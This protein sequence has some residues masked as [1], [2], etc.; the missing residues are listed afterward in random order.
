[1]SEATSDEEA[2]VASALDHPWHLLEDARASRES[3]KK[4]LI[5]LLEQVGVSDRRVREDYEG[6]FAIELLQNAHDACF[7]DDLVGQ[8]WFVLTESA[9]LVGNQG[10][11]FDGDR[12]TALTRLGASTKR[13]DNQRRV[14]GYK[15]IGF[16]SVFSVTN[17]P[18]I[19]SDGIFFGFDRAK[20]DEAILAHLGR[21]AKHLAARCFPFRLTEED[22]ESDVDAVGAL[23]AQGA[24]TVI[25][26]PLDRQS[27]DEVSEVV[28]RSLTAEALLFMPHLDALT[29]EDASG[30]RRWKRTEGKPV[31]PGSLVH[32]DGDDG[33]RR[34]WLTASSTVE[35]PAE[36]RHLEDDIWHTVEWLNASV[37]LPWS[38]NKIDPDRGPQTLHVYFPTDDQV[39]RALLAHG[40]FFLH[41]SRRF[42]QDTGPGG[43]VTEAVGRGVVELAVQLAEAVAGR[44]GE[45]L[46]ALAYTSPP[47]GYGAT[48]S[49]LLDER[50]R[51]AR[52][53]RSHTRNSV[54]RAADLS[55]LETHLVPDE[56]RRLFDA[57][58]DPHTLVAFDDDSGPASALLQTL[59]VDTLSPS[60][61]AE[62][63]SMAKVRGSY[64]DAIRL[65]RDWYESLNANA[66]RTV[67]ASL[68]GNATVRDEAGKWRPASEVRRYERDLPTPPLRLRPARLRVPSGFDLNAFVNTALNVQPLTAATLF[69]DVLTGVADAGSVTATETRKT[70]R[71]LLEVYRKHPDAFDRDD[72]RLG[73]VRVPTRAIPD[74][75]G[76]RPDW[77]PA[78]RAYF[79]SAVTGDRLTEELYAGFG[80]AEFIDIAS[81]GLT[82]PDVAPFLQALGVL[83]APR[84][85]E[86]DIDTADP[87][88]LSP[89]AKEWI[90]SEGVQ[91]AACTR[92]QR[93]AAK[94]ST[95]IIDRFD[96][97]V[98]DR[99][100]ER[101]RRLADVIARLEE[102]GGESATVSCGLSS[103]YHRGRVPGLQSWLMS[104]QEWIPTRDGGPLR[105]AQP[106]RAWY[107]VP[108]SQLVLPRAQLDDQVAERLGC[109]SFGKPTVD[110][111]EAALR[112][113]SRRYASL[114]DAP[115]EIVSTADLLID[116]LENALTPQTA[117][118]QRVP[119]PGVLDGA[120]CW[121]TRPIVADVQG[122]DCLP[123]VT[124]LP[125][126]AWPAVASAYELQRASEV[127]SWEIRI[128]EAAVT[129]LVLD[130]QTRAELVALLTRK[131]DRNVVARLV[132]RLAEQPVASVYL[133][134][135]LGEASHARTPLLS[136]FLT[137]KVDPAT[138]KLT[139]GTL[140]T[141]PDT[142][143][144]FYL[145]AAELADYLGSGQPD[146][147]HS[148]FTARGQVLRR[149]RVDEARIEEARAALET[150]PF[151]DV[152]PI[153]LVSDPSELFVIP[154]PA[155]TEGETADDEEPAD[156]SSAWPS[157]PP[158]QRQ[159]DSTR[160]Q[161]R[162]DSGTGPPED[163]AAAGLGARPSSGAGGSGSR[164]G[165]PP[166]LRMWATHDGT[167]ISFTETTPQ[168]APFG[169]YTPQ[170][171][172]ERPAPTSTDESLADAIDEVDD[173]AMNLVRAF[174]ESL[175]ARVERVDRQYRGWDMEFH[176][177][178]EWWPVEVKGMAQESRGFV[179]TRNELLAARTEPHYRFVV[180]TGLRAGR[181]Q[182]A[183][184]RAESE[185]LESANLEP[186]SWLVT[187]WRGLPI[188]SEHIW[189]IEHVDQAT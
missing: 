103:C 83:A 174:G 88:G 140:F 108:K 9:L 182:L 178:D 70:L 59:G 87:V 12:I 128:S 152:Q 118:R 130:D 186:L 60:E 30:S 33:Q 175:D 177:D 41:S 84:L 51:Q 184:V 155:T 106:S 139:G 22:F 68:T 100:V 4:Q 115:S 123:Q 143:G 122:V 66:K 1:M 116:R 172:N 109:V 89:L 105:W 162:G 76:G 3:S 183:M 72:E 165:A 166:E 169:S 114:G 54:L 167:E 119:L 129:D 65:L 181:G 135:R 36:T 27:V 151:E 40:D 39:G 102:P 112:S 29:V 81:T 5:A 47:S 49:A 20:A 18:Q 132:G 10:R 161:R 62:R 82:G 21:R 64:D 86:H 170:M 96:R 150:I 173:R 180:V 53:V 124:L 121:S 50:L 46:Q 136:F 52:I 188:E 98:A 94:V 48:L 141:T 56:H 75:R 67:R 117:R 137:R 25:R 23:H 154:D 24:V 31:G 189:A 125:E 99:D 93:F 32:L 69:D 131:S 58:R 43:K 37:A 55:V 77:R 28:S 142:P 11:P 133:D 34:S 6:R 134:L 145:L 63:L 147:I 91:S 120:R 148:Y 44:G 97:L 179:I 138:E 79:P 2:T 74:R 185:H 149:E 156:F 187:P 127:V 153:N 146:L 176:F 26:L 160:D 19:S 14:I 101:N 163:G 90:A 168:P 17:R 57:L 61:T 8:A 171:R 110:A 85:I 164:S 78:N 7:D 16:S 104:T 15:G 158:Q 92:H 38:G 111:V 42:V 113:L 144:D 45:L 73:E 95:T 107:G 126:G 157:A 80:E 71:F 159:A 13:T 35:A